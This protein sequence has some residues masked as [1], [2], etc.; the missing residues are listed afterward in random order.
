MAHEVMKKADN[1]LVE[2]LESEAIRL[3][4]VEWLLAQPPSY[5]IQ[6][7]QVLEASKTSPAP[8]LSAAESVALVRRG[9]TLGPLEHRLALAD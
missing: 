5:R 1:R 3:V 8:L 6:R 9:T 2:A 7:R 4:R